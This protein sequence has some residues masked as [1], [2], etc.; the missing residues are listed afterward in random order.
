MN[1]MTV[2]AVGVSL[3]AT[4]MGCMAPRS[5]CSGG[6]PEYTV[7]FTNRGDEPIWIYARVLGQDDDE[8]W[9]GAELDSGQNSAAYS[10]RDDGALGYEVY[11]EI[12]GFYPQRM[13][14]PLG[15]Q[16]SMC[17]IFLVDSEG[18]LGVRESRSQ[19]GFSWWGGIQYATKYP[20]IERE[21]RREPPLPR[22]GGDDE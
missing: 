15:Q 14:V 18:R 2:F 1:Q 11:C 22:R 19:W 21:R 5:D 4:L 20:I 6:A 9:F 3:C 17:H 10:F 7:G 13:D 8:T 12:A 16:G